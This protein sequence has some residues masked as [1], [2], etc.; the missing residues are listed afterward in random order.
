M[1]KPDTVEKCGEIMQMLYKE[2]FKISKLKMVNLTKENALD[3]Y[4]EHEGKPFL[5]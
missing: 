5:P 2:G 4:K 1:I 3:F